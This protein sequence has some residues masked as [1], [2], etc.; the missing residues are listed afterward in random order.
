[1]PAGHRVHEMC[2][3]QLERF[4]KMNDMIANPRKYFTDT[5]K[6]L[7][8]HL[9]GGDE[10]ER[11]LEIETQLFGTF[12]SAAKDSLHKHGEKWLIFPYLFGL[13]CQPDTAWLMASWLLITVYKRTDVDLPACEEAGSVKA[14]ALSV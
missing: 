11:C 10:K 3:R 1:M 4:L 5:F 6:F 9:G 7:D 14:A 12:L 8:E 2:H 13:L